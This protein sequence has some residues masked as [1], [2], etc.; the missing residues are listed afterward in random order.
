MKNIILLTLLTF[1]LSCKKDNKP[2]GS[3][4]NKEM[5]I[6][7]SFNPID[8]KFLGVANGI[9]LTGPSTTSGFIDMMVNGENKGEQAVFD[10]NIGVD[11]KFVITPTQKIGNLTLVLTA[12][13]IA[14]VTIDSEL[15]GKK[16]TK[17]YNLESG[18]M[19]QLQFQ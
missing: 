12:E 8:T 19:L 17:T 2:D 13:A 3:Y 15:G 16:E 18:K 10:N 6:T 11:G 9:V 7:L 5:K 14:T 4:E 1:I